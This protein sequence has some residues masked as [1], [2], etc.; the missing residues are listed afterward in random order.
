MKPGARYHA[1]GTSF[2]LWAPGAESVDLYLVDDEVLLPMTRADLDYFTVATDRA[3]AGSRYFFRKDGHDFPDPASVS[4]PDGVHGAS[5]V[6]DFSDVVWTDA[7]F[8]A[9]SLDSLVIYEL[10]VGT[11]TDEGSFS[12]AAERLGELASLGVTAV[13][14]M[15]IAEFPGEQNWGYDGVAWFAVQS[16][17]GGP[18]AFARFVDAAH[19]VGL[20]VLLDV[21]FNHFGPEGNYSGQYGDYTTSR[22]QTPWG[23][24]INLD[25]AGSDE[26]RE[27][28]FACLDHWVRDC[29]VDGFRFDAVHEIHDES[30]VPFLSQLAE[31]FGD[32]LLIAESDL[33]DR[34]LVLPTDAGGRGMA[35]A[36]ADDFHH[37]VHALLTGERE[38][39]YADFG[40]M[41]HLTRT[42]EQG[43]F[44]SWDYSVSRRRHHGNTPSGLPGRA[45]VFCTQN[46]DQVG[47]RMLGERL[48]TLV[49]VDAERA[50]RALLLLL[51]YVPLLFMGQ[52]YG[53]ERPF[54]YFVDHT[55]PDLLAA[56]REGRRREFAAFHS[57]GEAP[58]PGAPQ[59]RSASVLTWP[60][61]SED[62]EMTRRLLSLRREYDCFRPA[63]AGRPEVERRAWADGSVLLVRL[64]TDESEALVIVNLGDERRTVSPGASP[65]V[66]DHATG[67]RLLSSGS[68]LVFST[69]RERAGESAVN[70]HSELGLEGYGVLVFVGQG[71]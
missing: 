6:I 54:L 3:P 26:V 33:N 2:V 15:P 66:R 40:A 56:T 62:R 16:S 22:H 47:N 37:S 63:P 42:I 68:A 5:Q 27:F 36:W 53:E 39:Y 4:Q 24:A 65:A 1:D 34:R 57:A 48:R 20:A 11:F 30:A 18:L 7:G 28:M 67:D 61:E 29:H 41:E 71:G 23:D 32:K 10:H 64:R 13:E 70:L 69:S 9:P 35:S 31:R 51:P 17:Y 58:D 52:E 59:T 12:A 46:H 8:A 55:D 19:A 21:V 43:W 49:G 60:G 38:G 44:Y 25:G 45:F 50:A 14:V